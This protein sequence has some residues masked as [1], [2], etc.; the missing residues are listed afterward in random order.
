MAAEHARLCRIGGCLRSSATTIENEFVIRTLMQQKSD[1]EDNVMNNDPSAPWQPANAEGLAEKFSRLGWLGFWIQ[2]ALLAIPLFLFVYVLV[3]SS[4]DSA[5]RRG[6]DLSNYLSYGSLL[7]LL[8]TTFWFFRYTRLGPRI[9]D[10]VSRP[11]QFFVVKVLWIG[12]WA[13]CLGILFSMLLITSS[14]GRLLFVMLANP[15]TGLM[16]APAIGGE[17]TYSI[18]AIDA[19][20]LTVLLITLAAELI[21]VGFTLWLL[22]RTTT[23]KTEE[24]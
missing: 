12:L 23:A 1:L 22:F 4:P 15:Q 16:V 17:P 8:F 7:V 21:V 9:A 3:M 14:V 18:S 2:V 6:I 11:T 19:V 5:L 20:S 10:P 13:S 24:A